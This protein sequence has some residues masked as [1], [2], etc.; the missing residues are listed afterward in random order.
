MRVLGFA[1]DQELARWNDWKRMDSPALEDTDEYKQ[2][3]G[4][5]YNH[6][7]HYHGNVI[8]RVDTLAADNE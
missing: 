3:A 2:G 7:T 5:E 6:H 1:K 4:D 8:C